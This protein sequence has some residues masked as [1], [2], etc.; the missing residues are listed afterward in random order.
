MAKLQ[1][2]AMPHKSEHG[3]VMLGLADASRGDRSRSG[4]AA[5]IVDA[6]VDCDGVL[7]E[8]MVGFDI[9][10]IVGFRRD[11]VFGPMLMVGRG[12]V[13]VSSIRTLLSHCCALGAEIEALL[14]SLRCEVVQRLSRPAARRGRG[15]RAGVGKIAA[16][17]L[18][19][20]GLDEIEIN[21]LGIRIERR[22]PRRLIKIAS[23]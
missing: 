23:S 4:V 9:E 2:P 7:I 22:C 17:F 12:G 11:P 13:E 5:S 18:A 15:D 19:D 1:S 20:P 10:L 8:Q 21:P 16:S 14:R 6:K 3:G